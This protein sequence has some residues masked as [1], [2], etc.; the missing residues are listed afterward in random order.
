MASRPW[1][2]PDR[3]VAT[4]R[5]VPKRR[6][7]RRRVK[8]VLSPAWT[9]LR[10][11]IPHRGAPRWRVVSAASSAG[12]RPAAVDDAGGRPRAAPPPPCSLLLPAACASRSVRL[13][14][15]PRPRSPLPFLPPLVMG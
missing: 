12:C 3:C 11:E 7:A 10:L 15:P 2:S 13:V 1:L 8:N 9:K 6:E 5:C 14:P 4:W